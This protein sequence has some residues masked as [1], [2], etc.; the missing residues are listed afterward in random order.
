MLAAHHTPA[1]RFSALAASFFLL[2]G[3]AVKPHA[4]TQGELQAIATQDQ[5]RVATEVPVLQGEL[6][7]SEAIARAL[8]YNLDHRTKLLEQAY[9]AGALEASYYDL[10]PKLSADV[11]YST[12]NNDPIRRSQD[13]ITG[14]V[15]QSHPFI[16]S[17]RTHTATGLGLSWSMLDFGVSYFN[18]KQQADRVM[19]ASERRRK[20]MH[21]LMRSVQSAYWR[22][23]SAQKLHDATRTTIAE[24]ELALTDARKVENERLKAPA[25]SLRY[26]RA[27]L[28][29]LRTLESVQQE[30]A[31][32]QLELAGLVNLP[33]GRDYRLSEPSGDEQLPQLTAPAEQLEAVAI[34]NNPDLREENYNARIA[35][36]ETRKALVRLLPG[37]GFD[38]GYKHDTDSYLINKGWTEASV[39]V[40]ANLLNVFSYPSQKALGKAG[41]RLAQTRRMALQMALVTQV[42]VAAQQFEGARERFERADEIWRVDDRMQTLVD[43]G[44]SARTESKLAGIASH[45]SAILSLLRRYQALSNLHAA[46]GRMQATLGLEPQIGSL[47]EISLPELT[48]KI[49]ATFMDWQKLQP[50]VSAADAH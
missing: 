28:E 5:R 20:A 12:R 18:A 29:N 1:I 31:V 22:A 21:E 15:D 23:L 9:A 42:H 6:T 13:S 41:E 14:A 3:C 10:L 17:D 43:S 4:L 44:A 33:P 8:K 26:Q 30:L 50:Q 46:A 48:R 27:L 38:Y 36:L 47:D 34:A 49:D 11:D 24:A 32:A 2:G 40:S 25:E 39:Q 37:I 19:I 7:L 45:T 35:V 16:S